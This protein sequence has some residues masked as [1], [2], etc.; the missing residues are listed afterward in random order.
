MTEIQPQKNPQPPSFKVIFLL[1]LPVVSC[2]GT[3]KKG[4]NY[5]SPVYDFRSLD[6]PLDPPWPP[7]SPSKVNPRLCRRPPT[8]RIK[9][10]NEKK[11][12]V[13]LL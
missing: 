1:P 7:L 5:R 11:L 13:C 8:L 4:F 6:L 10:L 9:R 3:S 12:N 2:S